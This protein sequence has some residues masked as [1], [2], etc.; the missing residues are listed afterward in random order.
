MG[1]AAWLLYLEIRLRR[2]FGGKKARDLE[3]VLRDVA[4]E[5]SRLGKSEAEVEKYLESVEARLRKSV[6]H[7]GIVRFN[8]FPDAG[9]D[10][11]FSIAVMDEGRNGFVISSLYGREN[12][13]I[14]AKPL[15]KGSSRYRLSKEELEA[16]EEALK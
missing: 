1:L 13:R 15:E 8:P 9:S 4:Q 3:E 7:L 2:V 12:S 16:I 5:L 14:Y 10:Q 11:S 6:Q